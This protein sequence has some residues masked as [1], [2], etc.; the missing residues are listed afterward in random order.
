MCDGDDSSSSSS[1]SSLIKGFLWEPICN[2]TKSG[3]SW[4]H[5][6]DKNIN[7]LLVLT[8]FLLNR[9][10]CATGIWLTTYSMLPRELP[11]WTETLNTNLQSQ[12]PTAISDSQCLC[13]RMAM[14]TAY[15]ITQYEAMAE[16][17][18]GFLLDKSFVRTM[19]YRPYWVSS[20]GWDTKLSLPS[21]NIM[22]KY[23]FLN[24]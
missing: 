12:N 4:D 15:M 8:S 11:G 21:R 6:K 13:A 22:Q 7:L 20:K 10:S 1:K 19:A 3:A 16:N 18:S 5:Q 17:A 2:V 14:H 24:E 9:F 23:W